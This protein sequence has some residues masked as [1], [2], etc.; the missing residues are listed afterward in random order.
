MPWS[1]SLRIA[2][3]MGGGLPFTTGSP[4][5]VGRRRMRLLTSRAT[6]RRTGEHAERPP[7]RFRSD[8]RRYR[9]APQRR[10][11]G[12]SSMKR[13][14]RP[15]TNAG[16]SSVEYSLAISTA[17]STTTASGTLSSQISS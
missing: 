5:G 13:A 11:L 9:C 12:L 3:V 15:F 6:I 10:M 1:N 8:G 2:V 4:A 16:E 7:D 17:S 14:S